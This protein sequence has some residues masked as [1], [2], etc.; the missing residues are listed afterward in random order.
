MYVCMLQSRSQRC[1]LRSRHWRSS[2]FF[3]LKCAVHHWC[4]VDCR[5]QGINT[6]VCVDA[7]HPNFFGNRLLEQT[8]KWRAFPSARSEKFWNICGGKTQL[9]W[10]RMSCKRRKPGEKKIKGNTSSS[11]TIIWNFLRAKIFTQEDQFFNSGFFSQKNR[12]DK[13]QCHPRKHHQ[14]NATGILMFLL[15]SIIQTRWNLAPSWQ[16]Y[17]YLLHPLAPT[18][19]GCLQRSVRHFCD[20]STCRVLGCNSAQPLTNS[21]VTTIARILRI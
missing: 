11:T 13:Q 16:H 10:R 15:Q 2:N 18:G 3:S 19:A 14:Q 4:R 8:F 9:F 20:E 21:G 6:C 5:R 7:K 1:L 17:Y 12:N